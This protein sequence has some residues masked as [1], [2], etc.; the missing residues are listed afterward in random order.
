MSQGL[1]QLLGT[2]FDGLSANSRGLSV[3]GQNISNVNTPGY[4]R[5]EVM[6]E[7]RGQGLMGV[8]V[9]GLRRVTDA[10]IERRQYQTSGLASAA[11]ERAQ[12]LAGLEALYDDAAG[13]GFADA[14]GALFSSFSGLASSPNDP[15][16]RRAVLAR[17]ETLATRIRETADGIASQRNDLLIKAQAVTTQVNENAAAIAK[18][19][20]E[21]SAGRAQGVDTANLEDQREQLLLGLSSLIDVRTIA[22]D[23]GAILV[24]SAGTTLVDEMQSRTLSI[25]I[26]AGGD[27]KLLSQQGNGPPTEVTRFLTGGKLAGIR[28]ARDVDLAVSAEKLDAFA[29]DFAN[30]VN[31]QH[32]A[33]YGLDGVTGRNLFSTTATAAGA[34]RVFAVWSGVAGNP[35]AIAASGSATSLPGGSDNAVLLSGLAQRSVVGGKT[36]GEAYGALVGDVGLR[37]ARAAEDVALRESVAAQVT[38]MR[39]SVSGVSLEEE[40]IALTKYQRAYEA[41]AKVISTVDQLLQ[42]LMNTVGR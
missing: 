19:N 17:A 12:N 13:S 6:L 3:T 7:T 4:A 23:S 42:E 16:A 26:A 14:V 10:V 25:D 40:M 29:F 31:A 27:L 38:S 32:A 20:R 1:V 24:Q 35:N 9:A 5:R 28:E 21:I 18:L 2:A 30:A 33:G 22:Q 34:A 37:K 36:A 15:T 11:L 41:S 8:N 39:E